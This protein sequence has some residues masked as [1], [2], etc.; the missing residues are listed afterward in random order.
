MRLSD[1]VQGR[2]TDVKVSWT[3]PE[4]GANAKWAIIFR[5]NLTISETK[6]L[7]IAFGT[8]KFINV[9]CTR[10]SGIIYFSDG[11]SIYLIKIEISKLDRD[12]ARESI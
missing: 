12:G 6:F 1:A 11:L 9:K 10:F 3:C 4:N 8:E 2:I 7:Y 5:Q